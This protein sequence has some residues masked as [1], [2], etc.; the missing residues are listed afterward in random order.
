M[1]MCMSV[2]EPQNE[3]VCLCQFRIPEMNMCA[4]VSSG[5]PEMNLCAYLCQFRIP[6]MNMC[7]YLCQFRNPRNEHVCTLMSV[8]DPQ[9]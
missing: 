1:N 3:H 7:A 4:Y 2:P 9:K 6:E 8:L 5:I